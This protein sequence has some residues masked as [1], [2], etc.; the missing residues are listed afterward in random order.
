LLALVL[1]MEVSRLMLLVEHTNHD[2]EEYRD[3]ARL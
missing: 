2:P 3:A 1:R